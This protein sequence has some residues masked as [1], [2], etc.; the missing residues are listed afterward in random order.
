M[1]CY[2]LYIFDRQGACVHYQEWLRPKS[3]RH[4]AGT[5]ADDQKQMFG[6]FWTLGSFCASLNPREAAKPQL[7]TPLKFGQGCRFRSFCTNTYKLHF[8]ETA[9]GFKF[10]LNTSRDGGDLSEVLTQAYDE[11]FVEYVIKHPLYTP[12][13]PF[14]AD[15]F[16]SAL[17]AFFRQRGILQPQ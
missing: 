8:M 3:I 9:S 17:N 7:G 12:G 5:R 13:Q 11:V 6:L 15:Q 14:V 2:N 4:G 10:V 16:A 1:V